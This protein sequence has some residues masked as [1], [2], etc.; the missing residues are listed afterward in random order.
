MPYINETT[1]GSGVYNSIEI[2][3]ISINNAEL[4]I[5][6]LTRR[7][8]IVNGIP[9]LTEES[10]E[11]SND[12]YSKV[13]DPNWDLTYNPP[14]P[15]GFVE[16]DPATWG[17][18]TEDQFPKIID[19]AKQFFNIAVGQDFAGANLYERLKTGLY[20]ILADMG[21]IPPVADGWVV[22]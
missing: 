7:A 16:S 1:A 17:G 21:R 22:V 12:N 15:D 5:N 18:L 6:V 11:I 2:T 19:P 9:T 13:L 10:H 3:Q 20:T 14:K 8:D 4:I